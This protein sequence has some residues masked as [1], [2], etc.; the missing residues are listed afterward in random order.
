MISS[1]EQLSKSTPLA[2]KIDTT[3]MGGCLFKGDHE[4]TK[5]E[6]KAI[7]LMGNSTVGKTALF[8]HLQNAP[9]KGVKMGGVRNIHL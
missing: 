9:M 8:N 7:I 4:I 2:D 1:S 6:K 5:L 3:M